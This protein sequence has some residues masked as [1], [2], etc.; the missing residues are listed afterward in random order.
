MHTKENTEKIIQM[1]SDDNI[2]SIFLYHNKKDNGFGLIVNGVRVAE[3]LILERYLIRANDITFNESLTLGYNQ[4]RDA[5][6]PI[7]D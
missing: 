4:P 1:V 6:P 3:R 7:D 2:S 5:K